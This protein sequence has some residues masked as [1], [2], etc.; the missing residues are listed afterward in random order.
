MKKERRKKE[1]E[2]KR[3]KEKREKEEGRKGGEEGKVFLRNLSFVVRTAFPFSETVELP[4]LVY[5]LGPVG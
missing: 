5:F 4:H 3:K 2:R 1:R